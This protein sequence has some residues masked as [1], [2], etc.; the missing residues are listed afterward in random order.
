MA[1][2][3]RQPW[4]LALDWQQVQKK[5]LARQSQRMVQTSQQQQWYLRLQAR[6]LCQRCQILWTCHRRLCHRENLSRTSPIP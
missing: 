5:G 3:M 6:L 2:I 1:A 4:E